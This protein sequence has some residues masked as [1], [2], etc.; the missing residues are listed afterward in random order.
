MKTKPVIL[1]GEI[2]ASPHVSDSYGV[3]Y[4]GRDEEILAQPGRYLDIPLVIV[5]D[6]PV[7]RRR[8]VERYRSAGFRFASVIAP[9]ADVSPTC[10]LQEGVIVQSHVVITAQARIAAFAKLNIGVKVFHECRVG[11]YVTLAPGAT[12]LGRVH[13]GD[14]A[15]IG[16]SSTVLPERSVGRGSTV[17]A[18]AVVTKDVPDGHVVA[19]VPARRLVRE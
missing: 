10:E 3:P 17:G 6:A 12:L 5:P 13:V 18:G 1:V 19:G 14:Q 4:L 11:E 16:A 15:Y 8:I 7:V 2:D 9:D